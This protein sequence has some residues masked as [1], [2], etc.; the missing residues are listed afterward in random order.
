MR[1]DIYKKINLLGIVFSASLTFIFIF[2]WDSICSSLDCDYSLRNGLLRPLLWFFIGLGLISTL[3]VFFP[4]HY[5][6]SWLIKIASWGLPLSLVLAASIDP[7]SSSLINPSRT[8]A[9]QILGVIFGIVTL[10]FVV[11]HYK[12]TRQ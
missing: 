12:K 2:F 7:R 6:K 5:F 8:E 11:W 9:V 1:I 10:L 3:L 4:S